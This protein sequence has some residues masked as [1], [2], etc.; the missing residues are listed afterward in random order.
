MKNEPHNAFACDFA[1]T[2]FNRTMKSITSVA[3]AAVL[4]SDWQLSRTSRRY[5]RLQRHC[6]EPA[7][8]THRLKQSLATPRQEF[9]GHPMKMLIPPSTFVLGTPDYR[10]SYLCNPEARSMGAGRTL[11]VSEKFNMQAFFACSSI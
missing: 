11:E 4:F 9:V 6:V 7:W 2:P 10:N 5:P 8:P 3:V 1:R